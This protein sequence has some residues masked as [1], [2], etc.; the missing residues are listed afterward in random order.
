[1]SEVNPVAEGAYSHYPAMPPP[2]P[3]R[4]VT[5]PARECPYLPGKLASLRAFYTHHMP[6][7]MYHAFLDAG[8]RRSG[9]VI[10]Q[11]VC[12]GCRACMPIRVPVERFAANKSLRRCARR[13]ADLSVR[14]EKPVMTEEKFDLYRRYQMERHDGEGNEDSKG[15]EE[16]LYQS[17]VQTVEFNYRDAAGKLVAVGI[18]DISRRSL[19]SVYFYFDPE[20]PKRGLGNFGAMVEIEYAR[21]QKIPYWYIG[22]WVKGCQ[23]MEYKA[24]FRPNELLYPDGIWREE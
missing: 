6:A 14:L 11:P 10:Y 22:Y 18:C 17:P 24:V 13:N 4:L 19:S 15:M 23:A 2:V 3:L 16:F 20:Q 21:K 1:M 7:D 12:G 5:P 8:F 9:K